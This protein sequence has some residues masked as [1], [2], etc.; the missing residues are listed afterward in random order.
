[1]AE[2]KINHEYVE[3]YSEEFAGKVCDSF[4]AGHE[5]ID[6]KQ[7]LNL[8]PSKQANLLVLKNLYSEWQEEMKR[9]ES[10]YFDFRQEDV[11]GAL[12]KFMNVV[13]QHIKVSKS[14]F[15]PM[16][17]SAIEDTIYLTFSPF[18]FLLAEISLKHQKKIGVKGFKS[19]EKYIKV[20]KAILHSFFTQ[21]EDI[22]T[23]KVETDDALQVLNDVFETETFE[24][25][26]PE[27]LIGELSGIL[28]VD[29]DALILD[30]ESGDN[31]NEEE[32]LI[33]DDFEPLD[34]PETNEITS[35]E[36]FAP[37]EDI[38][39]EEMDQKEYLEDENEEL[40]SDDEIEESVDEV[41][42]E[43]IESDELDSDDANIDEISDE[44]NPEPITLE[45]QPDEDDFHDDS[46]AT[47][48]EN[49]IEDHEDSLNTKYK[50]DAPSLNEK[51]QSEKVTVADQL[52]SEQSDLLSEAISV[53]QK[54]LF[55]NDLFDGD[56]DA[57]N[58]AL[59]KIE[60]CQNFDESVEVLINGYAK[61]NNWDM[62]S[63]VV[64]ELLKIV[65]RRFR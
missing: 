25:D 7:I 57:F 38:E 17:K 49:E 40:V 18:D 56:G 13:S 62:T 23:D 51:M 36:E 44:E 45:D 47:E 3:K 19:I 54:Y 39:Q 15:Q 46:T 1:M 12:M 14:Y 24:I 41:I 52:K 43:E 2:R 35:E 64:K 33:S 34:E 8:T 37:D 59:E 27:Q 21:L 4:F 63:E 65:F 16:L 32:D 42:S 30:E 31:G 22:G 55:V 48:E 50:S 10:P 29:V 58:T 6:G 60:K 61:Q 9:I 26:D 11:R 53:N 28:P 20:N 5:A